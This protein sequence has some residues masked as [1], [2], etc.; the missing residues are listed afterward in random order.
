[1]ISKDRKVLYVPLPA[2]SEGDIE[3]WQYD[4]GLNPHNEGNPTSVITGSV[5]TKPGAHLHALDGNPDISYVAA[6]QTTLI[7]ATDGYDD[8]RIFPAVSAV[9][10]Y[11][12]PIDSAH[13]LPL[14][15]TLVMIEAQ[16]AEAARQTR[17]VWQSP[18]THPTTP[19]TDLFTTPET[20]Q[21]FAMSQIG[22]EPPPHRVHH[23][24]LTPAETI[25]VD[26]IGF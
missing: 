17:T 8:I 19:H 2:A 13:S 24:P 9:D 3:K 23:R 12:L 21:H 20:R 26:G 6:N 11:G 5:T 25:G 1:V 7:F 14:H 18:H 10:K 16:N 22:L 4:D 15:A